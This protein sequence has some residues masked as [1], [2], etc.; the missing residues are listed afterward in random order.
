[1]TDTPRVLTPDSLLTLP[2]AATALRITTRH[3]RTLRKQGVIRTVQ[4]GRRVLVPQREI[5]R[6]VNEALGQDAP[7]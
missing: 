5:V 7:R 1:M 4:L 6:L 3:L 2:E